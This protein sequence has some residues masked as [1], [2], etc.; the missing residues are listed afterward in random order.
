[1]INN[2]QHNIRIVN[3]GALPLDLST[4][5]LRYWYTKEPSGPQQ[6]HIYWSDIGHQHVTAEFK[7]AGY[8]GA[9]HYLEIG[10][11]KSAGIL[12]PGSTA[13]IQLGFN[14]VGWGNYHQSDDY[15]FDSKA[16]AFTANNRY[17]GYINGSLVW[18][19][20]PGAAAPFLP[21][22]PTPKDRSSRAATD[23]YS[24]F[25]KAPIQR[26]SPTTSSTALGWSTPAPYPSTCPR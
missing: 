8:P 6:A 9:D 22:G 23:R 13:E 25:T 20:E 26:R 18:G 24:W 10:F 1:M 19:I 4:V 16:T 5:K 12:G 21:T 14:A 17:T 3:T 11:T 2:I 15:S 7:T